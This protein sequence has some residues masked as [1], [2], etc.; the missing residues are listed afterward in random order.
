MTTLEVISLHDQIRHP[1]PPDIDRQLN[2]Q[3]QTGG[4]NNF[5]LILLLLPNRALDGDS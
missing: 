4:S 2:N 3:Q 5:E 1:A